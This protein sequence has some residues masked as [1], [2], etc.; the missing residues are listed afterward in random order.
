[1]ALASQRLPVMAHSWGKEAFGLLIQLLRSIV[2]IVYFIICSAFIIASQVIGSPLYWIDRD[3]FYA[4]AAF[5]KRSF[6]L[7]ATLMTHIWGPTT[8]RISGDA[9]VVDQ[10]KPTPDG[11]VQFSFP[12]RLVLVANHQIYTDW[13]YLWWVAYA[14]R[15]TMAGHLYIILKESLKYVPFIG[16]SM[17]Y[18][19]FIFMSRK[20]AT[21]QPRLAYRINKL[22]T[23]KMAPDG[24]PYLDPMW[25]LLFPEGTNLSPNGRKKSAQ[26]A[27]KNGL[28]DPDHVLLP[29]STGIFFCLNQLK[30]TVDSVY[31]CT[32]AYEGVPRGRFGEELFGL[33]STYLGGRSPKSVNL[34]W[35]RYR[36]AD[37]PLDDAAEFDEWLRDEWYKKDE[38]MEGYLKTGRF[39]ALTDGPVQYIEAPIRTRQVFEIVEI[40]LPT[41]IV[42]LFTWRLIWMLV[43]SLLA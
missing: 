13:L 14:N 30:G 28:R 5:T 32:V 25:L 24:R 26:W 41:A 2:L 29:R 16:A 1:M 23:K 43:R 21:D 19:G 36:L 7:T 15:P 39:P 3:W 4:Y 27:K 12:E 10:I 37:L 42:L 33:V 8:V 20:M 38:L 11:G 9:S 34:Y 31:D 40:F 17:A 35:R 22:K 6:A 18:Y